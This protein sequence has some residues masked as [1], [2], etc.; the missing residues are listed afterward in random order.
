[1]GRS[2][3]LKLSLEQQRLWFFD[4]LNPNNADFNVTWHYMFTGHIDVKLLT[5][6]LLYIIHRHETLRT[7]FLNDNGSPVAK[8]LE[9]DDI[10]FQLKTI[11]WE[12]VSFNG[13]D[14]QIIFGNVL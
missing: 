3:S 4:Q 13:N 10:G 8:I 6:S 7:V 1:M 9:A 2:E 12:C 5:Q 14:C 11:T